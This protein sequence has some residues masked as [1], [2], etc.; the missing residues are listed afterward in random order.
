LISAPELSKHLKTSHQ[1][2]RKDTV[3]LL[4]FT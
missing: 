3:M 1:N 2:E 4:K